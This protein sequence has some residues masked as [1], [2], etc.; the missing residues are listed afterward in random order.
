MSSSLSQNYHE[1][2]QTQIPSSAN[3]TSNNTS[4]SST[5]NGSSLLLFD[6]HCHIS[7]ETSA[8]EYLSKA[9]V[10]VPSTDDSYSSC[11]LHGLCLCGTSFDDWAL[12][13]ET[14]TAAKNNNNNMLLHVVP[15]FGVHPWWVTESCPP[16]A[17]IASTL[18]DKLW[19]G[20]DEDNSLGTAVVGEIG[21]DRC[22]RYDA[23]FK[24]RLQPAVF[25]AQ[26]SVA[27]SLRRVVSVHAVQANGYLLDFLRSRGGEPTPRAV[28][29]HSFYG[30]P[31]TIRNLVR[32]CPAPL[33]FG[34]SPR[35]AAQLAK[36]NALKPLLQIAG[37]GGV[38]LESDTHDAA[39]VLPSLVS[40]AT[41][42]SHTLEMPLQEVARVTT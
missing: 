25:E 14:Y 3:A 32:F 20:E 10:A 33:F 31:D 26:W 36:S 7:L 28:V 12:V 38:L 42:L 30:K 15:A 23:T 39:Q 24:S 13:A 5:R 27:A 37:M 19:C 4:H 1:E 8:N 6:S 21:I 34:V 17:M 41:T 16:A 2:L 18:H 40:V 35:S 9:V 11:K 22:A 29:L